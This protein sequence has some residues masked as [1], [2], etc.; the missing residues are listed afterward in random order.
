MVRTFILIG[1]ALWGCGS[2]TVSPEDETLS[3]ILALTNVG[4]QPQ[5]NDAGAVTGVHITV[6]VVNIGLVSVTEPFVMTWRL[7]D[8][9]GETVATATRRF[10]DLPFRPAEQRA[11]TLILTFAA[12]PDITGVQDVVT[13]AFVSG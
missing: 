10:D 5:L 3:Q 4:R 7:R 1:M 13:F 12:R 8:A 6:D 2:S 11:L 9:G